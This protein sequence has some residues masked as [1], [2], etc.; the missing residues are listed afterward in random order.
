MVRVTGYLR[1]K[2]DADSDAGG[3]VGLEVLLPSVAPHPRQA[4]ESR[5]R[6]FPRPHPPR[7][8]HRRR[9]QRRG[10]GGGRPPHSCI[11]WV[12][13]RYHPH[14]PSCSVNGGGELAGARRRERR[15]LH[16]IRGFLTTDQSRCQNNHRRRGINGGNFELNSSPLRVANQATIGQW[17]Q[18]RR[19]QVET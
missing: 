2:H 6:P 10:G 4:R 18:L 19:W 3:E 15:L 17:P 11:Q 12:A 9:Q 7:P 13:Q 8:L 14:R 16:W 5:L 1:H